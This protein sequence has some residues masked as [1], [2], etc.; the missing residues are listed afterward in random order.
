MPRE[1]TP[2][3]FRPNSRRRS[4]IP[5]PRPLA[6]PIK[7]VP[8]RIARHASLN[9]LCPSLP[10][11]TKRFG[12]FSA[13]YEA[14]AD[15]GVIAMSSAP[16]INI[17]GVREVT[18]ACGPTAAQPTI[19]DMRLLSRRL[20]IVPPPAEWPTA[21]TFPGNKCPLNLL[22]FAVFSA[23]T[24]SSAA[25]AVAEILVL[26]FGSAA[27]LVPRNCE[28]SPYSVKSTEA[29]TKPQDARPDSG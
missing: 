12:A 14:A 7:S 1:S 2:Q 11:S 17:V 18:G 22:P 10:I 28:R 15:A 16:V 4:G 26:R 25:T 19:E 23:T 3:P 21:P 8:E 27:P 5:I 6:I 13:A 20:N 29:T 24:K 9:A